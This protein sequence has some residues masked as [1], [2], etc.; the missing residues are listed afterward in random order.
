MAVGGVLLV[1]EDKVELFLDQVGTGHLN[2]NGIA[3]AVDLAT[4]AAA[5][6]VIL[7]VELVEVIVQA[8]DPDQA[9]AMSLIELDIQSPLGHARDVTREDATEPL[10]HELNLLVLDRSALGIGGQLLLRTHVLALVLELDGVGALLARGILVEQ[11]VD[12]Q[13]GIS[14]DG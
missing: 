3:E 13:V 5:D 14:A 4:A 11:A 1:N 2:G 6:A 8:T 9:F 7:L 12:H 10:A